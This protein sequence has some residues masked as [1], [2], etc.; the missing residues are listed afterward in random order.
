MNPGVAT[1]PSD[2]EIIEALGGAVCGQPITSVRRRPYRY[3]TSFLLEELTLELT[4]GVSRSFILKDLSWEGLTDD[5]RRSKPEFLYEP[6]R[7]LET[8]RRILAPSG[9]GPR[10]YASADRLSGS[11]CW[12]IL[13]KVPGVELWQLG[14]TRTWEWVARWIAGMHARFL[15][16]H[17]ELRSSNPHL[18]Q[19]DREWFETWAARARTALRNSTDERARALLG[20]LGCYREVA[21]S[22]SALPS[23]F[24]HG[25]FFPSNIL[26]EADSDRP[27]VWPVDWEMAAIGPGLLDTAALV[28]G[29]DRQDRD[30]L[31]SAYRLAMIDHGVAM[32]SLSEVLQDVARCQLHL[33]LQWLGWARNWNPPPEHARDWLGEALSSAREL[34]L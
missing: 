18:L 11:G 14:D 24:V 21:G 8:Y 19:Y 13:E 32:G 7:E 27:D 30:G 5:A 4:K 1:G 15:G 34:T 26:V 17:A 29:W 33:A 2:N 10:C 22:L 3:A 6:R 23:T 16:Q 20:A 9:I 31:V 28:T 25:E 12:L